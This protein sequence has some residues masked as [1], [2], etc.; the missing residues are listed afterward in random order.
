MFTVLERS[1]DSKQSPK[2]KLNFLEASIAN[3]NYFGQGDVTPKIV[4]TKVKSLLQGH[5]TSHDGLVLLDCYLSAF[6]ASLV[7]EEALSWTRSIVH[8]LAGKR[9]RS[10]QR[11]GWRLLCRLLPLLPGDVAGIMPVLLERLLA[12]LAA[13][14]E[15]EEGPLRC[16][17]V[18]MRDYGKLMGSIH[19]ALEKSLLRLLVTW[20][21]QPVQELVCECVALL[22][23]CCRRASGG[24]PKS[25]A[26]PEAWSR[27]LGRL[28]ATVHATLDSL[29][30]DL[31]L[32]K[33]RP[34]AEKAVPLEVASLPEEGHQAS[35]VC[36]R[37]VVSLLRTIHAMLLGSSSLQQPVQI[38]VE[39]VL[40]LVHRVLAAHLPVR[41]SGAT[42]QA[43]LV[44]SILPSIQ[45]EAVQLLGQLIRC[46]RQLLAPHADNIVSLIEEV[47]LRTTQD[48]SSDTR[49][50]RQACYGALSLWLQTSRSRLGLGSL[51]EKLA[52]HLLQDIEPLAQAAVQLAS[53][54]SAAET[55][56]RDRNKVEDSFNLE[57][58]AQ[59]CEHALKALQS[60]VY[61]YGTMMEPETVLELQRSVVS[62]VVRLQQPGCPQPQ[63]YRSA[64]C[65]RAL[66]ALLLSLATSPGAAPPPLHC[67]LRLFSGGLRDTCCEV[68]ELCG[69][70]LACLSPPHPRG[71]G[72]VSARPPALRCY[73]ASWLLREAGCQTLPPP[74]LA[75][76]G[77]Q[78][79]PP[80]TP[81]PRSP[82]VP[83]PQP[84]KR[85]ST[86][87][88]HF[89]AKRT[90]TTLGPMYR[91]GSEEAEL[92]S[93]EDGHEYMDFQEEYEDG[94]L[95]KLEAAQGLQACHRPPVNGQGRHQPSFRERHLGA[96][97]GRPG[98]RGL[99]PLPE[100]TSEEED[101]EGCS[102]DYDEEE[103]EDEEEDEDEG[104]YIEE[105]HS[106]EPIELE[107]DEVDLPP[108]PAGSDREAIREAGPTVV[109]VPLEE[110]QEEAAAEA[111]LE[112][113]LVAEPEARP[114]AEP[115]DALEAEAKAEPKAEPEAEQPDAK[116][117]TVT[118]TT[119]IEEPSP[120]DVATPDVAA[121]PA[122]SVVP[123]VSI[124]VEDGCA[125][126]VEEVE[127]LE[128]SPLPT[129]A[130]EAAPAEVGDAAAAPE[131]PVVDEEEVAVIIENH[132]G[133][134]EPKGAECP[135][136][137]EEA[138]VPALCSEPASE[139]T[140]T[141]VSIG[142]DC[143]KDD[144]PEVAAM[145]QDFVDCGPDE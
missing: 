74:P 1:F 53:R 128:K 59:L 77:C 90:I 41:P 32:D 131:V 71:A 62:L 125:E 140:A 144:E 56:H 31:H 75:S 117:E 111:E 26:P 114:G 132:A 39:D 100:D 70:A 89:R 3:S 4:A 105:E 44:A 46:C 94:E 13:D 113:E 36:W 82:A 65:R 34:Q 107:S 139:T 99:V 91:G 25:G 57:A 42:A 64:R 129:A 79:V 142:D 120:N 76:V 124:I 10:A 22:P 92:L 51:V 127:K 137:C 141:T 33:G 110:D 119:L 69:Q 5:K 122:P 106:I 97:G 18:C 83:P 35:L 15:P 20:N 43:N 73:R 143:E 98:G 102:E 55:P 101:E 123:E 66:Y 2:A 86:A 17:L 95:E 145:L 16:L 9:P 121:A 87:A 48:L 67:A 135:E 6:P 138:K 37:R 78:A 72:P 115:E 104:D 136:E 88:T 103:L 85:K 50:L 24:G 30:Q 84:L 8:L 68:A 118:G 130:A 19:D 7:Q 116:L 109:D 60:L 112:A 40:E 45:Y 14:R 96:A 126:E 63:P 38:P 29:F 54:S 12:Q 23:G 28:V 133:E 61:T 93:D 80:P 27:Q 81:A 58:L 108:P 47:V 52:P 11:A 134:K 49:H 21:S